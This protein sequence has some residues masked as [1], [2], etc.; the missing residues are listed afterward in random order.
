MDGASWKEAASFAG[1]IVPVVG[2]A[3]WL[4]KS[5]F[6][7]FT[8]TFTSQQEEMAK[9]V[10]QLVETLRTQTE[11]HRAIIELVAQHKQSSEK[12][13]AAILECLREREVA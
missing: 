5:M 4:M 2:L 7:F 6:T 8:T 13:H 11:E 9:L 1:V 3:V 10:N 12:A